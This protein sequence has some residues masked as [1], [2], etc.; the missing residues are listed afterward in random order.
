MNH[1]EKALSWKELSLVLSL[2][3]LPGLS[4]MDV[5]LWLWSG[6]SWV[7]RWRLM[8]LLRVLTPF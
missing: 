6:G 5:E 1:R 4:L 7:I 3:T 2:I 8:Q